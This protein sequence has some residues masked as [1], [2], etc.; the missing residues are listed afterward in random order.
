MGKEK[1]D[2]SGE[3]TRQGDQV[4]G[5]HDQETDRSTHTPGEIDWSLPVKF[6]DECTECPDCGEPWCNDCQD[7]YADCACPGPHSEED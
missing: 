7:H 2:R 3:V 6:A 5:E 4:Q 1:M